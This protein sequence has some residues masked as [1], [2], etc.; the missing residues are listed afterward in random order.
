MLQLLGS[1]LARVDV[2]DEHGMLLVV[3]RISCIRA[4]SHA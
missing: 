4:H 2:A 3:A 1:Y